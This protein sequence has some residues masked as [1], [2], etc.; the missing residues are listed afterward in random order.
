MAAPAQL[1][2]PP[3]PNLAVATAEAGPPQ[4]TCQ[5]T[6]AAHLPLRA[7]QSDQVLTP[8]PGEDGFVAG[9]RT[10]RLHGT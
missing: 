10:S 4:T 5:P 3:S 7:A 1:K 9:K 8:T 2:L 6:L